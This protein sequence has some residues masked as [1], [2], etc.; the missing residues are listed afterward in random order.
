MRQWTLK[1]IELA[2]AFY[3][4]HMAPDFSE[5]P[6]PRELFL[7][8]IFENNGY[9]PVKI[10]SLPEGSCIH[11][12]VPVFQITSE[13]VYT[14]LCT[15]LETLLVHSWYPT[16]VATLSRRCKDIIALGFETSAENGA[17]NILLNSR[18]HDFGFRGCTG[19]EQ[20]VLGG[21]AHLLNFTGT[22]TLSAAYYAQFALNEGRPVGSSIP[23][24]EHSVMTAWPSERDAVLNMISHFGS[25]IFASVMDSFDYQRA[26]NI[27]VPSVAAKQVEKGGF[28][29]LRPDSGVPEDAVVAGLRAAEA[30][31]GADENRTGYK[32]PR[33]V[34]VI[35]G[36]GISIHTIKNIIDAVHD[37]GY[38]AVSVAF[39][40]GGG[41]LQ[42]VNR[43]TMS[44]AVKLNHIVYVDGTAVDKMK[45]PRDD[46]GKD[47]LPGVLA[48]KRVDG[49]PRVFPA[50][51]VSQEDNMLQVV[52]DCGPVDGL[53]W[54]TFDQLRARVEREWAALPK[55]ADVLSGSLK[56]KKMEIATSRLTK[57]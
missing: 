41:L 39:G 4:S 46:V 29:V 43:D 57:I 37:A 13:G 55:R 45:A 1:D 56:D 51:E 7:K 42:K 49:V 23:A 15:F 48:V 12:H 8:F 50:E 19:V 16:T 21:V 17:R 47:S 5:F 9:L 35:Q 27:V 10:E 2:D 18:L 3:S 22:D 34:G 6:Y 14:P 32:V 53:Q 24:T 38:S 28:W 30:A 11:A 26:L 36:D 44:F 25:G 52:Y 54:E 33:G 40:M 31:F 20:S